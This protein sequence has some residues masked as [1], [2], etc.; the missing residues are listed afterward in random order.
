[1][2]LF[3]KT[4]PTWILNITF[5]M[6]YDS[7]FYLAYKHKVVKVTVAINYTFQPKFICKIFINAKLISTKSY[8]K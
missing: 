3:T 7:S 5:D 2:K 4:I 8:S 1:M 6:R